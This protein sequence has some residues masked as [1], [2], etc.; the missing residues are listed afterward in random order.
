MP[1]A[2][3][4]GRRRLALTLVLCAASCS[5][6]S[7]ESAA[8]AHSGPLDSTAVAAGPATSPATEDGTRS[9]PGWDAKLLFASGFE[10]GVALSAP[11]DGGRWQHLSGTDSTTGFAWPP[12]VWGGGAARSC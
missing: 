2:S 9:G 5:P 8:A 1:I 11:R 3:R 7:N 4:R 6:A 12:N 10:E